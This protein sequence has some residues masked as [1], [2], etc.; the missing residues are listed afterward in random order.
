M[1]YDY[2]AITNRKIKYSGDVFFLNY[3]ENFELWL[4]GEKNN[5]FDS[6]RDVNNYLFKTYVNR[7]P[8]ARVY[9]YTV[10][11]KE[12]YEYYKN[13]VDFGFKVTNFKNKKEPKAFIIF[14]G[15]SYKDAKYYLGT[16]KTDKI[17]P[18]NYCELIKMFHNVNLR[19]NFTSSLNDRLFKDNNEMKDFGIPANLPSS[20][21]SELYNNTSLAPII[22]SQINEEFENIYCYDFDSA[23][24]AQ[25]FQCRF[26]YKFTY[27]GTQLNNGTENFIRARFIN[28]RAKNP[29]FLSLSVAN[30]KNGKGIIFMDKESKRVLI[31]DEVVVS[32]FYNLDMDVIDKDYDYDEMIIEKVWKVDMKP[33][34]K[35]FRDAVIEL[36]N[37]KEIAK[38]KGEP[39]ADKK[40]L[41]NR[42]HGFFLTKKEYQGREEQIYTSLPAQI[43]FYT[44][45]RQRRI[46]RNLIDKIGLENIISAHTDSIKTKGCYDAA[47]EEYNKT[48]KTKYSDTLGMLQSEGIMEKVV[49]FS[50]TRAKYIMD[51]VFKTKHGGIDEYTNNMILKSYT[52]ETLNNLSPY[53]HTLKKIFKRE[54]GRN[55]LFRLTENR[56]FSEGV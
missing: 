20:V 2:E 3:G 46:M 38:E 45:A 39:Y 23:Y 22:Y 55:Y 29:R 30:R 56:V 50:N 33:L 5:S 25:Y 11:F 18:A 44:I 54:D 15:I 34:P 27:T 37:N 19:H 24:I 31:A 43:G 17:N 12:I 9:I 47:V 32:F 10:L 26:P 6:L 41:L 52:Y 28:I 4:N 16:D 14:G 7:K 35:S 53:P 21:L 42:I 49:Y 13:A 8:A 36:Y 40:V 48:H 1:N 51:G